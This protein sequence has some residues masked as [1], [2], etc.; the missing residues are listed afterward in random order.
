MYVTCVSILISRKKSLD[1]SDDNEDDLLKE[2]GVS[3][4]S[5]SGNKKNK[6]R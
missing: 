6:P 5:Y 3:P 1:H 4:I 2:L